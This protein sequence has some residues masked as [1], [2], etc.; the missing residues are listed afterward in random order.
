[1]GYSKFIGRFTALFVPNNTLA[2]LTL[3]S[4]FGKNSIIFPIFHDPLVWTISPLVGISFAST[5]GNFRFICDLTR[6][7]N[8]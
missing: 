7:L 2:A 6:R 1:M 8:K 3:P 5:R 4:L